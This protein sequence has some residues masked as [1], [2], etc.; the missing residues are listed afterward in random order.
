MKP[1]RICLVSKE[2]PPEGIGGVP[3]YVYRLA[4]GLAADGHDVTL[5][6]GAPANGNNSSL[7]HASS[8]SLR[9]YRVQGRRFPLPP[10]VRARGSGIWD[11]LE[12]SWIVDRTI[13]RLE[14][15]QGP[16]DV[17]EMPNGGA[18]ALFYSLHPR[19][20]LVVRVSTPLKLTNQFKNIPPSRIGFPLHLLLEA[21][22]VRRAHRVIANS[23]YNG[24]CCVEI[25]SIPASEVQVIHHG[26]K[27]PHDLSPK[28]SAD[29]KIIR[30]L[31]VG[32]LQKRKGIHL[33][34]KA[35]PLVA[36]KMP[37]VKFTIAGLDTG[38]EHLMS[39]AISDNSRGMSYEDFFRKTAA[40]SATKATTFLGHV[41]QATLEQLY[42]ECDIL[43]APSLSESFGLMY[44]EAMAHA[45]PVVAFRT[46]AAPEVVVHN[47]T[48]ILV[49]PNDVTALAY[50]LINLATNRE[51]RQEL[52]RRGYQRVH[53][54]FSVQRMV[55]ETVDLYRQVTTAKS[56]R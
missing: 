26:V 27:I 19:A 53:T 7:I 32:R 45:K 39:N 54:E 48:G 20:P 23:R 30:F 24:D 50:A 9:L 22:P 49:E 56:E 38:D 52:G 10:P 40:P 16:F 5:I 41:D 47:Q 8:P 18:E 11:L 4:H 6:A 51:L 37:N 55:S 36:E 13:A 21:L 17:V 2:Y 15:T 3:A 14:G 35:I 29:G 42:S 43:V 1:L 25:Y 44:A 31:Y 33:L 46:G 12:H 28:I 34:L